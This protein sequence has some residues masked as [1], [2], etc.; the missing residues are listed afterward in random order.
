M[1]GKLGKLASAQ[2]CA[3]PRTCTRISYVANQLGHLKAYHNYT[4]CYDE[5]QNVSGGDVCGVN[6]Y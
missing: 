2:R 6:K 3:V 5:V 4:S 1:C